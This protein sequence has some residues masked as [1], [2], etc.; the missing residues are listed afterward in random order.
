MLEVFREVEAATVSL[1]LHNPGFFF[2]V[3]GM[4]MKHWEPRPMPMDL[5]SDRFNYQRALSAARRAQAKA[6]SAGRAYVDYWVARLEFAVGYL[7]TI[8]AVHQAASAEAA[9]KRA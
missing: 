8:A 1:S 6:M 2:P 7:D 4:M 3:P 9:A 5:I